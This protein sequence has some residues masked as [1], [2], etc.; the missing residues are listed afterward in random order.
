MTTFDPERQAK[1][2]HRRY[3]G[4]ARQVVLD[5]IVQAIRD[6][7]MEAARFWERVAMVIDR[8]AE[9]GLNDQRGDDVLI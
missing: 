2:L 4:R 3:G 5:F 6:L 8:Y 7:D 9:R 1:T